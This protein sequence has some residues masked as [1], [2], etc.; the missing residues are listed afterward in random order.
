MPLSHTIRRLVTTK[1]LQNYSYMSA[2]NILGALISLLVYPYVIRVVGSEQYGLYV[3]LL[4]VVMYFQAVLDYGFDQPAARAIV[5]NRDD[6]AAQSCIISTVFIAKILLLTGVIVL[7]G[8]IIAAIPYLRQNALLISILFLQ[9]ISTILLPV[10]YFQG[11]KDMR[12]VT[13]IQLCIRL[14]QIPFIFWLV[15][16]EEDIM[17]YALII[18]TTTLLGGIIGFLTVIRHGIRLV[19]V[20]VA[21]IRTLFKDGTPFFLTT[22]TGM[23]KE[24]TLTVL[25]GAMC[26]MQEVAIYDLANKIVQIPRLFTQSINAAL[27]PE[28]VDNAPARR[29]QRILKYERIIALSIILC[30][31]ALGYPAI[32]LL[33]G[34]NMLGAYPLAIILSF[35]IYTYLVV[36][37]YLQFVFIPHNKYYYVSLNQL[38]A[39]VSCFLLCGIGLVFT[40]STM[41]FAVSLVLSGFAEIIFCRYICHKTHLL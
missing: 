25:I 15:R 40:H 26:G 17:I 9:P 30:I 1:V 34:E 33:G 10:W 21:S 38:V 7:G 32:Y 18:S 22:M 19:R 12:S 31:I 35:T 41:L 39:L 20:P 4:A 28:V 14:L 6:I 13:I 37:A 11:I 27:F 16:S 2:L 3:F 29:V 5:Q 8:I 36:G 24:R 23:I